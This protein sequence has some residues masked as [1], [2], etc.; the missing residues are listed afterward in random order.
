ML[1]H[2]RLLILSGLSI[3]FWILATLY[4]RF[5][6]SY[7]VDPI[8]GSIGFIT[9]IPVGWLSVLILKRIAALSNEELLAG[10]S[11]VGALAMM[12]DGVVLRWAPVVYGEDST[13]VRMGAAWLLWGYGVSF[14]IALLMTR[15]KRRMSAR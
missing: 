4:I 11:V 9:S 14:A 10:V 7:L 8:K 6:P 12:I 13:T 15:S 3:L 2:R 1:D 5:M